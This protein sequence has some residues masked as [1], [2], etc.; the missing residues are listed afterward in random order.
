MDALLAKLGAQAMNMAIRSGIALT[1][2]YAFSQCSRLMKTVDDK[3]VRSELKKLQKILDSKIKVVS[4]AID[5]V[6]FK[7]G[8]GNAFLE[9]ALPLAKGLHQDIVAL[10]HRVEQAAEA[11][12]A[13]KGPLR[14]SIDGEQQLA[15]LKAIIGDMKDLMARIDRDIPLLHMAITA[16][17]ESLS[18]KMG[19]NTSPS[20]LLQAG[21]FLTFGDTQYAADPS[22]PVQI[23]PAFTLS[24][25]MLFVG[26]AATNPKEQSSNPHHPP[27]TPQKPTR[28][29]SGTPA[30][31]YGFE[32]GERKP[33]WQEVIHKARVRLCRTPADHVFDANKGYR[34]EQ[35]KRQNFRESHLFGS[36]GPMG[37]HIEYAYHLE[38]IEDLDDGRVHDDLDA[39]AAPYDDINNAGIRESIPIHQIAKIFYA[40]TGRILNIGSDGGDNNPVLLLKRD[41]LAKP[42]MQMQEEMMAYEDGDASKTVSEA[43]SVFGEEDEQD[44]I[45]RQL[46]EESAALEV[47]EELPKSP[48]APSRRQFPSH[49]DPEWIAMEVFE[50]DDIDDS[51]TEDEELAE[52]GGKLLVEPSSTSAAASPSPNS[53]R[54]RSSLDPRLV[55]QIQDMSLQSSPSARD[56]RTPPRPYARDLTHRSMDNT[57]SKPGADFSFRPRNNIT[58]EGKPEFSKSPRKEPTQSTNIYKETPRL[59]CTVMVNQ[60]NPVKGPLR[61]INPNED[62]QPSSSRDLP[63]MATP[64]K[65][66]RGAPRGSSRPDSRDAS[67]FD[68]D[69]LTSRFDAMRVS[70]T[71]K[72]KP[73]QAVTNMSARRMPLQQRSESP[74]LV[75]EVSSPELVEISGADFRQPP[76]PRSKDNETS[77]LDHSLLHSDALE[78]FFSDVKRHD[79]FHPSSSPQPVFG[80]PTKMMSS[81]KQKAAGIFNDRRSRPEHHRPQ[82]VSVPA[83]PF[84]QDQKPAP[85][86]LYSSIGPDANPATFRPVGNFGDSEFYTDPAKASADLKALLEGGMEDEEEEQ[87]KQDTEEDGKDGSMEGLKVKL[88]PH[89]VEGVEWMRGRELGPVKRGKVPKGGIL[90]D[91]MGLGKTLQTIALILSNQ[92]PEKGEKAYKKHFDGIEKTTLVVAPLALIRQWESE[93]KEKVA[94]THGLKVC[95][96]HGPQ[97]TKRYKDLALYDVV[98]TTYQVLV[99]EWG[100]SSED[101]KGVKAGCFGLHWWRVVLDEAHTIKNRNAKSTKAC[102]A[103]R[104]E[105][106]WCLSGTPMQNNLEEL[107]SLIKF[108]RIKPYDDL[109]EWKE[110]IEKPLKN[111]KGHVAIRRLHSIL[112]CFMKR[113]TKDILKEAGALNPGGK[114]T[115]EGE[116]ST[117]GFKVTE[118][119]VVTVATA[120]SPAERRFYD[121]LEARADE[122]IEKMLKG[123]VDYANALVLLLRLRQACNHPK[124]V[125]GKLDKDK[126]ALSTG[127]APKNAPDIDSLADMFGVMGIAAKTCGICGRN[128]PKD[129]VNSDRDTCQECYDDLA[130]FKEHET[131]KRK[132]PKQKKMKVKKVVEQSLMADPEDESPQKPKSRRPRNRNVVVD[133]D[134]EE[135][136]ATWLVPEDQQGQLRLGK[137][138]GEEDENAEGGGDWIG[139]DDSRHDSENE[140]DGSQLD[141]FVVKDDGVK[142]EQDVDDSFA[143]DDSLPSIAAIASQVDAKYRSSQASQDESESDSSEEDTGVD[144]SEVDS[145]NDT[146]YK[147]RGQVSQILASAKI[148]QMMKLLHKEADDHKFIVFSQ[149]TSMMDLIEPFFRKEGFKFTRYDGSMKNDEREASLHRLRNDK[150]TRILLCSLKCGSLG[151][152]LTAATRVIILEPFWNPFVEEQAIDR[153]HRLTQTV[154]VVVYKLTVEKTV[155]ER[156]L[157]LQEKKRLLAETA[158]EGGMK[159]DAFKLGFKEIMDLFRRDDHHTNPANHHDN[160]V[161]QSRA[162]SAHSSRQV[163][164]EAGLLQGKAARKAPKR[165]EHETFGRRW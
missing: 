6:E 39:H 32:E 117:T 127:A 60:R 138:G 34:P 94:K 103:L 111:G 165:S 5:L 28:S 106:R 8:R 150:N 142:H 113:R 115:K 132:K 21:M 85:P 131:P 96:H 37:Q 107:Q 71:P 2:T 75:A 45:D 48:T 152:N 130:Y 125:E 80:H 3:A 43:G 88:L 163:S 14:S 95:V 59:V 29:L 57:D 7:S 143:S 101:E 38:I 160:Y 68:P 54:A 99:S 42:P 159:K 141:S 76:R 118:R 22:R 20:R 13:P 31:P 40:D 100:H 90:A 126:D 109:K 72:S 16:S 86:A 26:H 147:P 146:R 119:K 156:I 66:A 155:E 81:L 82:H 120:F 123:K 51:D 154:D 145:D 24:I 135:A 58:A 161:D 69:S 9:S 62:A 93:I 83:V 148:R 91:D 56:L 87:E 53:R 1:S 23:G 139:S 116:K 44:D 137:A 65:E 27:A 92:K 74:P 25:Y 70:T 77:Q 149:F 35:T 164:P 78:S 10:G 162:A 79:P 15:E 102:Y 36:S 136:D 4:P 128:L 104:S 153:V 55:A 73:P 63:K 121:R 134:D 133:S 41:A 110:Q 49:L 124:L 17:G 12:E 129:S 140:D 89:Q 47:L 105:Y 61:P 33:V 122:S 97:R 46:R 64:V 112:R 84:Y 157:Q 19:P 98:V 52:E 151:L 67:S 114:P 108:L 158:I 18:S 30:D 144:E 50:E 11:A